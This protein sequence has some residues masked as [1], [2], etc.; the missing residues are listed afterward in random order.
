MRAVCWH[1]PSGY[2]RGDRNAIRRSSIHAT[3]LSCHGDGR[4]AVRPPSLQRRHP[5]DGAG[6][7]LGHEFMGRHVRSAAASGRARA[8]TPA[9]WCRSRS[10][11]GMSALWTGPHVPVR[12]LEP[13]RRDGG[14]PVWVLRRRPVGDSHLYGGYAGG[15]RSC[16]RVPFADIGPMPIPRAWTT[17][18]SCP[19]RRLP[20]DTCRR[21]LR[22][23]ARGHRRGLGCVPVGQFAIR[24]GTSWAAERAIAIDRGRASRLAET[25]GKP[26]PSTTRPRTWSRS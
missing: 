18:R 20:T 25:A 26:R 2:P 16:V 22:H 11:A 21:E 10:R 3:P 24:C 17:R 1:A 7:V 13:E 6:E 8:A 15:Q 9:W 14:S 12:Q 19:V 4:F 5:D 23:P